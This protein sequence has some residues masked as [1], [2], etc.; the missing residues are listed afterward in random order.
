MLLLSFDVFSVCRHLKVVIDRLINGTC[1]ASFFY[2]ICMHMKTFI[3]FVIFYLILRKKSNTV[4]L[5]GKMKQLI[6][7]G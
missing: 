3:F 1:F 5:N 2:N 6:V 4:N 7:I